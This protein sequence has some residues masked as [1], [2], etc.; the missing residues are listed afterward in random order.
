[1]KITWR[2]SPIRFRSYLVPT[3]YLLTSPIPP[4][5]FFL[6]RVHYKTNLIT[7][8]R[9]SKCLAKMFLLSRYISKN[10]RI[11]FQVPIPLYQV[12]ALPLYHSL[13]FCL[14]HSTIISSSASLS[15]IILSSAAPILSLS[16]ILP[17][18]FYHYLKFYLSRS[19]ILS[20]SASPILP[21]SQ[22]LPLPF[23]HS[24]KFCIQVVLFLSWS[25]PLR[26]KCTMSTTEKSIRV[27]L[28]VYSRTRVSSAHRSG[29]TQEAEFGWV[30][31]IGAPILFYKYSSRL[32]V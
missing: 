6:H 25:V 28:P 30:V 29:L 19:T 27:Q 21:L 31:S 23:Y 32:E 26:T 12:P 8:S 18:L 14:S 5:F 22:V 9:W 16:Q 7:V 10:G 20:S 11:W 2:E 15:T 24:L 1:M 13:K 3:Y 4:S 17:L